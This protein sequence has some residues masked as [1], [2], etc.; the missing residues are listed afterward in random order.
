MKKR[1]GA[2]LKLNLMSIFFIAVSF[3]SVTLAWFA[4]SGLSKVSTEVG[5]KAWYIELEKNGETV[6]NDIIISLSEIY[7]GMEP[8]DEIVKIK[9]L[10]DSDAQ[11]NYS[12]VSARILDAIEDNYVVDEETTSSEYVEDSLS[13]EYPFHININLS[14]NYA[15]SKGDESYFEVSI[16]WP[17]DA[18]ND[19]QDSKWGTAA[20]LFQENEEQ[21]KNADP[22]YQIR[23]AIQVIISVTAEQYLKVATSSD[24]QYNLGDIILFDAVNNIACSEISSTCLKTYV[25]DVNNTLGDEKVTLLPDPMGNY[26]NVTYDNYNNAY[27]V[28]TNAWTVDKRLL[29]VKDILDIISDDVMNS[30]LIR[31]SLSDFIIGNLKYGNRINTEINRAITYDGYYSFI[32][33]RFGYL[34]S[35]NCYWTS[36]EYNANKAFA[37]RKLDDISKI[38]GENKTTTCNVIPVIEASKANL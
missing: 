12:I 20:H 30:F 34:A 31:E 6:T 37:I 35:N 17:L 1:Y 23:P 5:V 24:I 15:L 13:H 7:P 3:I 26:E 25:I 9:N 19:S 38:Y 21:L 33:E 36:S 22:H 10:G 8:V 16:S 32:N 27:E 4:Y 14:K 29:E 11:V 28:I 2:Y 18:D